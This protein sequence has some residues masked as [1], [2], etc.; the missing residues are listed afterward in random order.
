MKSTGRWTDGKRD[1]I[2]FRG[3]LKARKK[4]AEKYNNVCTANHP[5]FD[6]GKCYGWT[7]YLD[8]TDDAR[9]RVP[10]DSKEY[11]TKFKGRQVGEQYDSR[12]GDREG[13][14]TTHYGLT[15]IKNQMTIAHLTASLIAV[16]EATLLNQPDKIRCWRTFAYPPGLKR[17][18]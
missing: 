16:A 4:V 1:R 8:V 18:A 3:T 7:K 5:S 12:L 10:R 2:K 15:A 11:K 9:S 13:E 6:T 17:S 14:Q